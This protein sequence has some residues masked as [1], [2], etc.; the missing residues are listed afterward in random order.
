MQ[1]TGLI[2]RAVVVLASNPSRLVAFVAPATSEA[3]LQ[4]GGRLAL[5]LHC[6]RL[7]SAHEVPSQIEAVASW[8][9]LSSGKVDRA[10]LIPPAP[11][12]VTHPSESSLAVADGNDI[13][14]S[15]LEKLVAEAF[16]HVLVLPEVPPPMS[17]FFELGGSSLTAVQLLATLSDWLQDPKKN[18]SGVARFGLSADERKVLTHVL[19]ESTKGYGYFKYRAF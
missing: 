6:R 3:A 7:L 10:A 18:P 12:V 17:N 5:F 13:F 9:L 15:P 19:A 11:S 4:A 14:F 8:P 16:A 2:G 1:Q